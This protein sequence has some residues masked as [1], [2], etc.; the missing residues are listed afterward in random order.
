M[1][2]MFCEVPYSLFLCKYKTFLFYKENFGMY[3]PCKKERRTLVTKLVVVELVEVTK[4][5]KK[6]TGRMLHYPG[7]FVYISEKFKR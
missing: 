1:T 2:E 5:A 7:L 3:F 4:L 6:I